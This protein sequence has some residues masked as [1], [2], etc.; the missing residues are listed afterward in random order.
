MKRG[1]GSICTV[2][3]AIVGIVGL[4]AY[5]TNAGTN[6]F[7]GL[8]RDMTVIGC[9]IVGIAALVLWLFLGEARPSWKDILPVIA[10]AAFI[11]SALTLVNS[12]INGIAAI[13]TFEANAQNQADLKSALVAIGALVMAAV[14]AAFTAFFD[15]KKEA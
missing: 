10:P 11:V 14:L 6:Y 7:A 9:A 12:R 2:I 15:V 5:L 1:F 13:M 4:A 3:T 8:G